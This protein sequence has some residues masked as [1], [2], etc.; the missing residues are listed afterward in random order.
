M[1]DFILL[2]AQPGRTEK[3]DI[4]FFLATQYHEYYNFSVIKNN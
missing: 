1:N 4:D 3:I 2:L